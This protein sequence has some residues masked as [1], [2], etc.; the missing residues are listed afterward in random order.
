M[1]TYFDQLIESDGFIIASLGSE[2]H[3]RF[4]KV[5]NQ[6]DL[7][8]HQQAVLT[9]L[10]ELD[11]E[12]VTSQKELGDIVGIDPRNIVPV[13]DSLENRNLVE[14]ISDQDDRRRYSIRL[15]KQGRDLAQKIKSSGQELEEKMF[16]AL[17]QSERRTLHD[18]L[19][20]LYNSI[21]SEGPDESK[22]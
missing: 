5:I 4:A 3:R 13:L 11:D 19:L 7:G 2:S 6:W 16:A 10:V 18:L 12:G 22:K 14:R 9:A 15:T 20:K 1:K 17:N 8:M 21:E